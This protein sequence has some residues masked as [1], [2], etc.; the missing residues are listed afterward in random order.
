MDVK[1]PHHWQKIADSLGMKV[2]IDPEKVKKMSEGFE[3]L[4]NMQNCGAPCKNGKP[5]GVWVN[6]DVRC[7]RHKDD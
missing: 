2:T 5:C 4:Q 1:N 7:W 6:G 3:Y